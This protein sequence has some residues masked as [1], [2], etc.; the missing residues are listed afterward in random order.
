M[1]I[2]ITGA[3]GLIG[4]ETS[5][6]L[7]K[8]GHELIL[9]SRNDIK[10][11]IKTD[12]SLESLTKILSNCNIV[13]HLAAKRGSGQSYDEY[14]EN[15]T[16]T[17]NILKAMD[18]SLNCKK[19]IYISSISVYKN[20][21]S[22]P[23]NE[24][25]RL[26]PISFYGLSKL[27]GEGLCELYSQRGINYVILRAAHVIGIEDKGYMLS[28][29]FSSAFKN[30][31]INVYGKSVAKRQ[32]IYVKDIARTIEWSLDEKI[33]NEI[34]NVG[35]KEGNT[36]LEIGEGIKRAF[37]SKSKINVDLSKEEGI[38]SSYMD[39]S[40]INKAGFSLKYNLNTALEDLYLDYMELNKS[41]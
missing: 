20:Q 39:V 10:P 5:K 9:L 4:R 1:K 13:I 22:L 23:W 12:Y 25:D 26:E 16:I 38:I 36:N 27:I 33:K 3:T 24:V 14:L 30:E 21:E 11:Y 32:F 28:K 34:Y 29:F 8:E 31:D 17:E 18:K 6:L 7:N 41:K 35:F 2:A 15:Q 37:R 40:K 19:I